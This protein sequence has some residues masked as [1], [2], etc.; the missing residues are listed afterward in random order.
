M[1]Y[2]RVPVPDEK[3][4]FPLWSKAIEKLVEP[5]GTEVQE[6]FLQALDLRGPLPTGGAARLLSDWLQENGEA[7][8]L[9][10]AGIER[11]RCQFPEIT[12]FG[13]N[14]SYVASLRQ[15]ARIKLVRSRMLASSKRFRE[16]G[17]ELV[18]ILRLGEM[19]P[20]PS[21]D[22]NNRILPLRELKV[23]ERAGFSREQ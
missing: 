3:N 23:K 14:I 6:P 5:E 18:K 12:E 8:D 16:A 13:A 17:E 11:G 15:A 10:D 9:I 21:L 4:A 1:R 2:E 22:I 7:L 20:A 19:M